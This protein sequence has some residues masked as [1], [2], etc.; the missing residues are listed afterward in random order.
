[1]SVPP[2]TTNAAV[3]AVLL[4]DYD[5]VRQWPLDGFVASASS[6]VDRVNTAALGKAIGPISLSP[7]ELELIERWLAAGLYTQADRIFK[8]KSTEGASGDF[9]VDDSA[10]LLTKNPYV[11][12]A[13]ANDYS[14]MLKAILLGR[15]AGG[16]W[17]GTPVELQ[18]LTP[19][20][21]TGLEGVDEGD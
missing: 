3:Q 4:K 8:S 12:V 1:M 17:M 16:V 10:E 7:V 2:R 13:M 11:M 6:I 19:P 9:Q 15:R 20:A 14:N 5:L 21:F 18:V